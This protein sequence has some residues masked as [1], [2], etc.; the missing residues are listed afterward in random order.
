M[1]RLQWISGSFAYA[2]ILVMYVLWSQVAVQ[3]KF[4]ESVED[5]T[6]TEIS[7]MF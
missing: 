7:K 5:E 4:L 2:R 6:L 3:K 1:S